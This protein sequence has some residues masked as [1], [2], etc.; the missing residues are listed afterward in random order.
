MSYI[1]R[2]FVPDNDG[3]AIRA[4]CMFLA[5]TIS[6]MSEVEPNTFTPE[7]CRPDL[8]SSSSTKPAGDNPV[9]LC[10]SSRAN[11]APASPA[12]MIIAASFGV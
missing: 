10:S 1:W 9:S 2:R 3:I 12:P 11:E 5:R 6:A 4:T 8:L 7:T